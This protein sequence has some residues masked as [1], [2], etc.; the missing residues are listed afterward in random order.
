[1]MKNKILKLI[2]S[3][4]V[5]TFL[6]LSFSNLV[7]AKEENIKSDVVRVAWY[8]WKIT[9]GDSLDNDA[10]KYMDDYYKEIEEKTGL[11]FKYVSCLGLKEG[12]QLLDQKK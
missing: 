6:F 1:M 8:S 3:L 11:K 9:G 7:L 12:V 5:M 4:F 2:S 10:S